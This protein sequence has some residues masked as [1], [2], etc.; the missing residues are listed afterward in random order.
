LDYIPISRI[1]VNVTIKIKMDMLHEL[2]NYHGDLCLSGRDVLPNPTA[3]IDK[4]LNERMQKKSE[5]L[6]LN[7]A[8]LQ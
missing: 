4:G 5:S 8:Q 7:G 3:V 6:S 1:N 2:Q